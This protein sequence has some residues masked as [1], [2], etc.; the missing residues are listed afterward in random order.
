M[1]LTQ[2]EKVRER[3][4]D[5]PEKGSRRNP[6]PKGPSLGEWCRTPPPFL[7]FLM[8]VTFTLAPSGAIATPGPSHK[9]LETLS[10]LQEGLSLPGSLLQCVSSARASGS[11]PFAWP[12]S[13]STPTP[14]YLRGNAIH[15]SGTEASWFITVCLCHGGL[16]WL[17]FA[18]PGTQEAGGQPSIH[19]R[20]GSL[21]LRLADAPARDPLTSWLCS[22]FTFSPGPP[23][24]SC[25]ALGTVARTPS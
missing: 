23:P 19:R 13:E 7:H 16:S 11:L 20:W 6:E 21:A 25:S 8:K 9:S 22:E 17:L 4:P 15:V 1:T 2:R 14:L 24:A 12:C 5:L 10:L 18:S 3:K